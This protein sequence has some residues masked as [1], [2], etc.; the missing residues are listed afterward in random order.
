MRRKSPLSFVVLSLAAASCAAS[1]DEESH[2]PS[3]SQL[4]IPEDYRIK[5]SKH[6]CLNYASCLYCNFPKCKYGASISVNCTTKN[7]CNE[8]HSLTRLTT[9]RY[10]YQTEEWEH[11]CDPVRVN[12]SVTAAPPKHLIRTVCRVKPNVICMGRRA[13]YKKMRCNW[14]SGYK[15]STAFLLSVTLGGFGVDRFYLG[16]W[17]SGI[18]KLFSF[19]GLGVWTLVDVVLIGT[20]Y[21]G[22]ADGS[23]YM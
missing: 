21:I 15:W 16:L 1:A 5:C 3:F 9:C 2:G 11:E 7:E 13:F 17:K 4:P 14:T 12:C 18:G 19:G 8:H 20:G 10:C 6:D 22:P 23:L